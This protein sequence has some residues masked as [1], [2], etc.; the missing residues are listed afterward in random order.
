M[1]KLICRC[2]PKIPVRYCHY[3]SFFAKESKMKTAGIIVIGDEILKGEV[4]DTNSNYMTT[5]LHQLG[6]KVKKISVIGDIFE[7]ICQDIKTFS[8][9]YTYVIT[10]GG[11]GPT[12]DDITFEAVAKAF[13]EPLILHPDLVKLCT[14]FYNTTDINSPGM[15]LARVPKSAKLTY[16]KT[17]KLNYPNVRVRNVYMFPGIPQLFERSFDMLSS[18]LFQSPCKFYTKYV[19]FNVTEDKIAKA[20]DSLVKEFPDV[21]IGSYPQ[22]FHR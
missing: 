16:L 17:A 9:K 22:L 19:Y 14:Q 3:S 7:D 13:D 1:A 18:T 5:R 10:T 8:Q 2:L 12:H 11:I 6:V 21:L 20:L 4:I 15:K